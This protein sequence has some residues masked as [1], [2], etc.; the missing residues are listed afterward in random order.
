[1]R[2]TEV[3]VSRSKKVNLG[4]YESAEDFVAMKAEAETGDSASEI[5][6]RL[7]RLTRTLLDEHGHK[8]LEQRARERMAQQEAKA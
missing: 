1:M 4:N 6:E 2:V 5:A 8:D 3:T 7:F